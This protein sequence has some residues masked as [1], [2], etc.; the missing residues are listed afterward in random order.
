MI[1]RLFA[2][3]LLVAGLSQAALAQSSTQ[4]NQPS[5]SAEDT[6]APQALPQSLRQRLNSAGFSNG[7]MVPGSMLITARDQK[8]RPVLTLI[9]PR[10]VF[11][12]GEIPV[13]NSTAAGAGGGDSNESAQQ[14]QPSTSAENTQAP[15]NVPET[16]GTGTG[17]SNDNTQ[18]NQPSASAE[19][20]QTPQNLPQSLRQQLTSAGFSDVNIVPSSVV[21]TAREKSGRPVLM[22]ITPSSMFFLT[23]IPVVSSTTTG[24]GQG[25]SNDSG[26]SK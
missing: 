15:Q 17:D 22:R 26:Q 9:T 3:A 7:N 19:N 16:T 21:I 18:Q 4:Q 13:A 8:G 2:S 20:T 6:Q 1:I 25:N 5:T 23:E 14:N 24:A 11:F 10:S 12:L